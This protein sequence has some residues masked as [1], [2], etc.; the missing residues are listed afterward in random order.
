MT[1][2]ETTVILSVL[3][4]LAGMMSPIVSETVMTARAVKAKNDALMI[5][6]GLT[7]LRK[8]VGADGLSL[9]APAD[10]PSTRLQAAGLQAARWPDVM[11]SDGSDPATEDDSDQAS[12]SAALGGKGLFS[13]AASMPSSMSMSMGSVRRKWLEA[14]SDLLENHLVRNT[15]GYRYRQ[16]GE[17]AGWNGPYI[18]AKLNGDPWGNRY[19]VNTSWL[20]GGTTAFDGSGQARRA[21][22][23]VSA[24]G[25]GIIETPYDQP[26]SDARAY[27]DD[28]VV[29]LQ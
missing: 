18:S 6:T 17:Y 16:P 24:G 15:Y 2:V 29:R 27:G 4:I 25:N 8:D 22:F 11:K 9:G 28:I 14:T 19:M 21:V 3:F 23:V 7:N 12:T 5:A 26:L 13:K 20:D 10:G 1:I